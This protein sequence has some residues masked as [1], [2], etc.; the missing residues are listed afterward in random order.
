[1]QEGVDSNLPIQKGAILPNKLPLDKLLNDIDSTAVIEGGMELIRSA[2]ESLQ[3][4]VELRDMVPLISIQRVSGSGEFQLDQEYIVPELKYIN[5]AEWKTEKLGPVGIVVRNEGGIQITQD[6]IKL[7]DQLADGWRHMK[8]GPVIVI[9]NSKSVSFYF[10]NGDARRIQPMAL[11]DNLSGVLA[12]HGSFKV[13]DG[14]SVPYE[15]VSVA[16]VEP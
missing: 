16:S 5:N 2:G 10:C 6:V 7:L 11:I 15:P 13:I 4:Q 14:E 9:F 1:V 12:S 8:V 3:A